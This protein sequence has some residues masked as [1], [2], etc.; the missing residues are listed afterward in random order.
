MNIGIFLVIDRYRGE[1]QRAAL[2]G[3]T[4]ADQF[5]PGVGPIDS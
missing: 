4:D 3:F 5:C 1:S 2:L